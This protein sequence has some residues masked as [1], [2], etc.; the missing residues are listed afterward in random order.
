PSAQKVGSKPSLRNTMP[1]ISDRAS[2]SSTTRILAFT[3]TVLPF[4]EVHFRR[5]P[6][7]LGDRP[8]AR[9]DLPDRPSVPPYPT[10]VD[11][12]DIVGSATGRA[13][14]GTGRSSGPR[15][16]GRQ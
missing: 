2:S 3:G 15:S 9:A 5:G 7:A 10:G 16:R 4:T 6:S 12:A 11:A 8:A 1:I 13:A 14:P